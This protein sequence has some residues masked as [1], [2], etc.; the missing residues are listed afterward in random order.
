MKFSPVCGAKSQ[1]PLF[2]RPHGIDFA[3]EFRRESGLAPQTPCEL[4]YPYEIK[5]LRSRTV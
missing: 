1:F 4:D 2:N 5:E 3:R